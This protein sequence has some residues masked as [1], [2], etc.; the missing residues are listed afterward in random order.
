MRDAQCRQPKW[1]LAF[2]SLESPLPGNWHGGFGGRLHGKGP[3]PYGERDLAVQPTLPGVTTCQ[4]GREARPQGEGAQVIGCYNREV[5]ECRTP[6]RYW[7]SSANCHERG[8][9]HWRATCSETGPRG[10]E[11]GRAEKGFPHGN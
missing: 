9:G 10:S 11:E 8:V 7:V 2:S 1:Y 4:G 6:K 3:H 5:C